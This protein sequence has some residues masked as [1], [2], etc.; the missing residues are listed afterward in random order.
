MAETPD[1]HPVERGLIEDKAPKPPGVM[2]KHTQSLVI[3][4]VAVLMVLIM[5]L[6]GNNKKPTAA[7]S[8]TTALPSV[9]PTDNAKVQEMKQ[10]IQSEQM[11]TRRG[12]APP[13][14]IQQNW[15]NVPGMYGSPMATNPSAYYGLPTGQSVASPPPPGPEPYQQVPA[16]AEDAL[17]EERKK[18]EY[19]SL[20]ASNVALT[21][22][23]GDDAQKFDAA[24]KTPVPLEP[25]PFPQALSAAPQGMVGDQTALRSLLSQSTPAS[26]PV[27]P[28]PNP[29]NVSAAGKGNT[30]APDHHAAK[31][32]A[33]NQ[34]RGKKY[35]LFEGTVIET[36]LMN[37]LDGSFA[38]PV[39][40]LVSTDVYSHD[41]QHVLIPAGT[42]VLGEAQKVNAFGQDRLAVFFHRLIMPDG[43][44]E[45]LY[46]DLENNLDFNAETSRHPTLPALPPAAYLCESAQRRRRFGPLRHSHAAARRCAS[47]QTLQPSQAEYDERGPG[48]TGPAG[49]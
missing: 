23:E 24:S 49:Q 25:P 45:T 16:T 9:S 21:Y 1:V 14:A 3:M 4:G 17:K 13:D 33:V 37:R 47:L 18:R 40:C 5:W 2:S 8:P 32:D 35:V 31:Q 7:A 20:F 46:L 19:E 6:T 22:R 27:N 48:T 43:Y 39:M 29:P 42:K 26:G 36:V 10:A 11:A 12:I 44:S 15:L 41:R 28:S 38:G 34:S 30:G